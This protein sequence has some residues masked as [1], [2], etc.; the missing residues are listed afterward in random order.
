MSSP[1]RLPVRPRSEL[2]C[3][4][5]AWP[6]LGSQRH[7]PGQLPPS[8]ELPWCRGVRQPQDSPR[9]PVPG[10]AGGL[11]ATPD[12][13]R[14]PGRGGTGGEARRPEGRPCDPH[15]SRPAARGPTWCFKNV[16]SCPKTEK[17]WR[18]LTGSPA[19]SSCSA[20]CDRTFGPRVPREGEVPGVS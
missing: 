8:S 7:F 14:S 11:G 1:E 12:G 6:L 15:A 19:S 16:V 18:G 13:P 4:P 20:S 9:V 17:R 3:F 10:E 5:R 2:T